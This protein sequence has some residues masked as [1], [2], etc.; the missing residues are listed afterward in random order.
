[1][2]GSPDRAF[3]AH[4]PTAALMAP[5]F[6]AALLAW[7]LIL[8]FAKDFRDE[9][10]ERGSDWHRRR[11]RRQSHCGSYGHLVPHD[12]RVGM[13]HCANL[14]IVGA[15]VRILPDSAITQGVSG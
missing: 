3:E 6:G 5:C 4:S 10:A 8:G 9:A 15:R 1:M 13:V 11:G 2:L 14:F 7:G 12:E